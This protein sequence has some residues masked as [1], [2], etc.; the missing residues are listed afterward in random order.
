MGSKGRT[1]PNPIRSM[2]T[3]RKIINRDLL[4]TAG[5]YEG[6]DESQGCGS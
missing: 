1:I 3:D 5:V 2:N 6:V 4:R